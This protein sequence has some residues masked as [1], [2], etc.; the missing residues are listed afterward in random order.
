MSTFSDIPYDIPFLP[1][2][3][4]QIYALFQAMGYK[5]EQS[6]KEDRAL[7]LSLVST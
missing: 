5:Y 7:D 2:F 4:Q 3:I 6:R 1:S